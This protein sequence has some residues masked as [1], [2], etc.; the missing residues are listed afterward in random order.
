MQKKIKLISSIIISGKIATSAQ[1]ASAEGLGKVD[2]Q[3]NPD[4]ISALSF[5]QIGYP[6]TILTPP[7]N[8]DESL[9][10]SS[11]GGKFEST[12]E[13]TLFSEDV[14]KAVNAGQQ[15]RIDFVI[16]NIAQ[17]DNTTVIFL[18]YSTTQGDSSQWQDLGWHNFLLNRDD[19]HII[20]AF[21]VNASQG[22]AGLNGI[23]SP[24]GTAPGVSSSSVV[25]SLNLS[26]LNQV[27]FEDNNLYF[28]VVAVPFINGEFNFA[29]ASIS[30]L[31][32]YII[33][34]ETAAQ[35]GSGSKVSN[36]GSKLSPQDSTDNSGSKNGSKNTAPNTGTNPD[37]DTGGK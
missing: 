21:E 29:A 3:T 36:Q 17:T 22:V 4:A 7:V 10:D 14:S 37:T 8:N 20:S 2:S 18:A 13:G 5:D 27:E 35:Q 1:L 11:Q 30:E 19:F 28:Q 33:A 25:A 12:A 9:S 32:H 31:D 24:L 6:L 34:R 16:N 15:P 23:P 26:D